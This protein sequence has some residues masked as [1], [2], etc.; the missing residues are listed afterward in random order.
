VS[1]N[2]PVQKCPIERLLLLPALEGFFMRIMATSAALAKA[3]GVPEE[4]VKEV[5]MKGSARL[6]GLIKACGEGPT[7]GN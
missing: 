4:K 5:M 3:S 7:N 1:W 6:P 2:V